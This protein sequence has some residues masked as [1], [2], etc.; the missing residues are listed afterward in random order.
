MGMDTLHDASR[1][2]SID[3]ETI[4]T[5]RNPILGMPKY[6]TQMSR[7]EAAIRKKEKGIVWHK[8]LKKRT[9]TVQFDTQHWTVP[10]AA[11]TL[12]RQPQPK[13]LSKH[14]LLQTYGCYP[15]PGI[16]TNAGK[17]ARSIQ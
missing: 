6:P 4:A 7:H 9:G 16:G 17:I 5:F 8:F 15:G 13:P 10:D 3:Q 12:L 2:S 11:D 14:N 1:H